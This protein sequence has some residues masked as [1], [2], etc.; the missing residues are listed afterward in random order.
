MQNPWV[1]LKRHKNNTVLKWF[2]AEMIMVHP[3]TPT[4]R[5]TSARLPDGRFKFAENPAEGSIEPGRGRIRLGSVPR[6]ARERADLEGKD[7]LGVAVEVKGP[8]LP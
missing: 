3:S 5:E 6:S 7:V 2:F 8:A 4:P 1:M